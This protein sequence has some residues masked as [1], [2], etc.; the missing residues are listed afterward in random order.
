[1]CTRWVGRWVAW[2][3]G[4]ARVVHDSPPPPSTH[5][6]HPPLSPH[7]E[8]STSRPLPSRIT[9]CWCSGTPGDT[10]TSTAVRA[11]VVGGGE[12][13]ASGREA[14]ARQHTTHGHAPGA[15]PPTPA[16]PNHAS[17]VV[18]LQGASRG[19]PALWT[20]AEV[21]LRQLRLNEA[22]AWVAEH[23]PRANRWHVVSAPVLAPPPHAST[24]Y[25][26]RPPPPTHTHTPLLPPSPPTHPPTH[27]G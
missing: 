19:G 8:R 20:V 15:H 26:P 11:W 27:R 5:H 18:Y 14:C 13:D 24:L 23:L 12:S 10:K 4:R 17:G 16:P 7:L 3:G 1:M 25:H 21:A 2:V 22:P 6:T 9:I